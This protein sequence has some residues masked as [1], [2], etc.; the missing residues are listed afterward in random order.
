MQS[1]CIADVMHYPVLS[2]TESALHNVFAAL[3]LFRRHQIRHLAIVNEPD[4]L[5]GVVSLDSI[6]HILVKI[7]GSLL[8]PVCCAFL[9]RSRCTMSLRPCSAPF[10]N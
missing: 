7:W 4:Q 9:I 10:N 1:T 8:K 6:R 2:M 3:F 5:V